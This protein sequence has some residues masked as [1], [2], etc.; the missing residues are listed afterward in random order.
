L[1]IA[2]IAPAATFVW[3]VTQSGAVLDGDTPTVDI[4]W[5]PQIALS[6]SLRLDGFGL[7]DGPAGVGHRRARAAVLGGLLRAA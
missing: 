2:A 6:I 5:I 3:L 4:E 1:P 7:A